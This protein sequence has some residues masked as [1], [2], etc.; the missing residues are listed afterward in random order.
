[1]NNGGGTMGTGNSANTNSSLV[2]PR[3]D[4]GT[5]SQGSNPN[6]PP[7]QNEPTNRGK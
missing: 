1:M 4:R 3:A 7:A 6:A 2:A 5:N